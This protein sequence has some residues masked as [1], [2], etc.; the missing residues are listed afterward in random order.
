VPALLWPPSQHWRSWQK[1]NETPMLKLIL[2]G[3]IALP[4]VVA[5]GLRGYAAAGGEV[6]S[7]TPVK[8]NNRLVAGRCAI[9]QIGVPTGMG[10]GRGSI[11]LRRRAGVSGGMRSRRRTTRTIGVRLPA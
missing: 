4:I 5:L 9:D 10:C 8:R 2:I 3:L 11:G 6:K 7:T 1:E